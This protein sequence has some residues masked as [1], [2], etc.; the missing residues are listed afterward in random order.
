MALRYGNKKLRA[1]KR[2]SGI[3]C[4]LGVEV[5]VQEHVVAC[6]ISMDNARLVDKFKGLRDLNSPARLLPYVGGVFG[7]VRQQVAVGSVL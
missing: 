3:I 7:K 1:I 6:D 4:Q 5:F 2:R